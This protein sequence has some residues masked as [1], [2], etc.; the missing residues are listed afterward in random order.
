[1]CGR[2]GPARSFWRACPS[3]GGAPRVRREVVP[4]GVTSHRREGCLLSG[5][6][7]LPAARPWGRAARPR[8]PCFPR[9]EG[10]DVGTQHWPRSVRSCEPALRAVRVVGG[11][12]RGGCFVPLIGASEVRH[13]SSPGCPLSGR[14]L[15]VRCP[16]AVGAGVREWGPGTFPLACVPCERLRAAGVARGRLR[17]ADFSPL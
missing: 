1:M 12:P 2:A 17:G 13:S 15:G 11:R 7:P 16:C 9:A 4:G 10:V 8:S 3:G 5:T 6:F 14:G